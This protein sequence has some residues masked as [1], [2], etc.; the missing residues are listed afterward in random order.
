M[1]RYLREFCKIPRGK[2]KR[3]TNRHRTGKNTKSTKCR[4]G[5]PRRNKLGRQ[6]QNPEDSRREKQIGE[7]RER[8]RERDEA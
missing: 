1:G 6:Q 2:G 3:I 8:E 7:E 4:A 5:N